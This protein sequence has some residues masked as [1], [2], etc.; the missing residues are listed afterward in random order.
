MALI[1]LD[2]CRSGLR[3]GDKE[4]TI[5][6]AAGWNIHSDRDLTGYVIECGDKKYTIPEGGVKKPE[7]VDGRMKYDTLMVKLPLGWID[8]EC[9]VALKDPS[10]RIVDIV[11]PPEDPYRQ[12]EVSPSEEA[13]I[14]KKLAEEDRFLVPTPEVS[15]SNGAL[16][17]VEVTDTAGKPVAGYPVIVTDLS[18]EKKE[19][20]LKTTHDG[21]VVFSLNSAGAYSV[22]VPWATPQRDTNGNTEYIIENRV[23]K[24]DIT[25]PK[26]TTQTFDLVTIWNKNLSVEGVDPSQ[27]PVQVGSDFVQYYTSLP[28]GAIGNYKAKG[29]TPVPGFPYSSSV[30]ISEVETNPEGSDAG[31]EYIEFTNPTKTEVN[32]KGYTIINSVGTTYT[33]PEDTKVSPDGSVIV[34]NP[35]EWLNN[36][37]ESLTVKDPTGNIVDGT[38]LIENQ[39]EDYYSYHR[40][41]QRD[42]S[43]EFWAENYQSPGQGSG[44]KVAGKVLDSTGNPL[45][46]A[47][48]YAYCPLS[49]EGV[50]VG[51]TDEYGHVVLEFPAGSQ[52]TIKVVKSGYK[53]TTISEM[54]YGGERMARNYVLEPTE[55]SNQWFYENTM[56]LSDTQTGNWYKVD[57]TKPASTPFQTA[58][59][60]YNTYEAA[61]PTTTDTTT[62]TTTTTTSGTTGTTT[63]TGGSTTT[64]GGSTT[65]TTPSTT[66]SSTQIPGYP[67]EATGAAILIVILVLFK[68]TRESN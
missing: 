39:E 14:L 4:D 67:L 30:Y 27:T 23:E 20:T 45:S 33:I 52:R 41:F 22:Q 13:E 16:V 24:N 19:D 49:P 6:I 47:D 1:F 48:V 60:A 42:T 34:K 65:T 43:Q 51:T 26:A 21:Y 38:G 44:V 17:A 68:K 62:T 55:E 57:F 50:Y 46:D 64:T 5:W 32:L 58:L 66:Q 59:L 25:L 56:T 53:P 37:S 2:G 7:M 8:K 10:G 63:T 29:V 15:K 61:T 12:Y 54:M 18:G 35:S 28:D 3:T 31:Q 11:S 40:W 9:N 36:D